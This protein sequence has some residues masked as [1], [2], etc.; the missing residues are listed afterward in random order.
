MSKFVSMIVEE[1]TEHGSDIIKEQHPQ[2]L[3]IPESSSYSVI[4]SEKP[5]SYCIGIVDMVGSTQLAAKLGMKKM[6]KYYQ[7]FLNFMSKI[8]A[9]YDG[10]VVKNIGDCLLFYF[11]KTLTEDRHVATKALECSHALVVARDLLC[12][13]MQLEC[14]PCVDY[15]VSLDYGEVMPMKSTGSKLTDM[16]GPA[17]NMCSKINRYAERN[18]VVIGGDM[19]EVAKHSKVFDFKEIISFPVG[20][21]QC[22]PTYRPI[23]QLRD[24]CRSIAENQLLSVSI[25]VDL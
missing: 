5:V 20:F 15:R 1:S 17:V 13:Q 22:Y 21:R 24:D 25:T 23:K 6:S 7:H 11:P 2:S 19:Y 14:L 12:K 18:G 4:F 8:I 9:E 16:I 10:R 3:E